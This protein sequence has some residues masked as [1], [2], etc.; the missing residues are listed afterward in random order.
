MTLQIYNVTIP[1]TSMFDG[2]V[3]PRIA[4]IGSIDAYINDY[5]KK[6]LLQQ[7][8]MQRIGVNI[9]VTNYAA[10]FNG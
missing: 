4:N 10:T 8:A 7:V 2:P 5:K 6:Y 3:Q 9:G 1:V